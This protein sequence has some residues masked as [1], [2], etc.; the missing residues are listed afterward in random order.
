MPAERRSASWTAERTSK[1][2]SPWRPPSRPAKHRTATRS[3]SSKART[4]RAPTRSATGSAKPWH[5]H[6]SPHSFSVFF[7]SPMPFSQAVP[8]ARSEGLV[9]YLPDS[10]LSAHNRATPAALSAEYIG[11]EKRHSQVAPA[12]R[13]GR[14]KRLLMTPPA[15]R[16]GSGGKPSVAR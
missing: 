1:A 6:A 13:S 16:T 8:A 14:M 3:P 10:I 2:G 11:S 5:T 4:S 15:Y 7:I 12:V 9:A